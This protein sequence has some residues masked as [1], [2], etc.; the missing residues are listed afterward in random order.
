MEDVPAERELIDN[1]TDELVSLAEFI[2]EFDEIVTEVHKTKRVGL[3]RNIT[4]NKRLKRV[5]CAKYK[6]GYS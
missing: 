5:Y 4:R 3:L 2:N 6:A 1:G